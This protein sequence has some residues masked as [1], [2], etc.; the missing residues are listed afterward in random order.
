MNSGWLKLVMTLEDSSLRVLFKLRT[1]TSLWN[2]FY[3][4]SKG[5]SYDKISHINLPLVYNWFEE[6]VIG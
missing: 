2:L 3:V 6:L 4:N 1:V 5:E